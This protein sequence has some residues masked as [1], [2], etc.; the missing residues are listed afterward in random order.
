MFS[1]LSILVTES[2]GSRGSESASGSAS[3]G[4]GEGTVESQLAKFET[5]VDE[6]RS[7][8]ATAVSLGDGVII[9]FGNGL[10][11]GNF[12]GVSGIMRSPWSVD[13]SCEVESSERGISLAHRTK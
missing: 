7:W 4:E 8:A 2:S 10:L 12:W 11:G 3:S 6:P 5:T 13:G 1:S 9:L